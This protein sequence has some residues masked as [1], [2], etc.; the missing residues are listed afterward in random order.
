[1][2]R[3]L[4]DRLIGAMGC[5]LLLRRRG[6]GRL[7]D[8][9]GHG[10][11]AT[12]SRDDT[13]IGAD[14]MQWR[15]FGA[16]RLPLEAHAIAVR[17]DAILEPELVGVVEALVHRGDHRADTF[18]TVAAAMRVGVVGIF[19]PR[20]GDNGAAPGRVPFVPR[21]DVTF[22]YLFV[23]AHDATPWLRHPFTNS[24]CAVCDI[25]C[26]CAGSPS[27]TREVMPPSRL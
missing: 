25:I 24:G 14:K 15:V 27:I 11:E 9:S 22:D 1:M 17:I 6:G 2:R 7:V 18:V 12:V 23:V 8:E 19:G 16:T 21:R 26:A 20:L 5:R 4:T 13:E 3:V 10:L